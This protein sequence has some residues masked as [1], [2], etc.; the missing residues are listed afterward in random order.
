M[1]AFKET[2]ARVKQ[3]LNSLTK[4]AVHIFESFDFL[5]SLKES[6][7]FHKNPNPFI[8]VLS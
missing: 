2:L 8:P 3:L 4:K 1:Q 7:W 6:L 5:L